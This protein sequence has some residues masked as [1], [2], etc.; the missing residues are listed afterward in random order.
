MLIKIAVGFLAGFLGLFSACT[1]VLLQAGVGTVYV[2]NEDVTLWLPVPM[3][4]AE[5]GLWVIPGKELQEVRENLLPVR[6]LVL[7]SFTELQN[8]PDAAFVE[9]K[10]SEESV[11]VL[12]EGNDLIVGA[13]PPKPERMRARFALRVTSFGLPDLLSA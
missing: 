12:K 5:L 11:L 13:Y 9:V 1:I 2:K 3:A 8:C 4:L 6:D 10:T 7:A